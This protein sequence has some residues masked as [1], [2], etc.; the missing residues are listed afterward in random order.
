MLH[1]L[2]AC[3]FSRLKV[4]R[5]LQHMHQVVHEHEAQNRVQDPSLSG[6]TLSTLTYKNL[7]SSLFVKSLLPMRD[8]GW[9][10][11]PEGLGWIFRLI[12]TMAFAY[13]YNCVQQQA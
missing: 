10:A 1:F 3:A 13:I 8:A 7:E 4:V 9:E 2:G 5:A 12:I 6:A 11:R